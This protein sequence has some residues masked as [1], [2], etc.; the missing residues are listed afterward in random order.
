MLGAAD[1]CLSGQMHETRSVVVVVV[2]VVVLFAATAVGR[3]GHLRSAD[4]FFC[5]FIIVFLAF[6]CAARLLL[7]ARQA[8]S[9]HRVLR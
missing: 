2:V 6:G 8:F 4:V 3:K 7:K 1:R 9:R 5:M